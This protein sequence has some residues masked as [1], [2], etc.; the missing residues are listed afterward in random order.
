MGVFSTAI[1]F[2]LQTICQSNVDQI[3]SAIILS[4]ESVF[5]TIM[6]V[7]IFHEILTIRMI[8]GCIIIFMS[9]IVSETK[10]SFLRKKPLE[11]SSKDLVDS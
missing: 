8:I 4:T 7:L 5:G 3:K 6:S 10:L 1:G 11:E 9:I 2:L